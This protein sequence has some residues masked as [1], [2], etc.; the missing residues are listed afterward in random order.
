MGEVRDLNQRW[1][2]LLKRGN[3]AAAK[4]LYSMY[5]KA[6]YNTLIRITG[7]QE[8]AK[9]LLQDSFVKA[10]SSIDQLKDDLAFGGWLKRIV[11]NKGIEFTRKHNN[12]YLEVSDMLAEPEEVDVSPSISMDVINMKIAGLPDGCREIFTLYLVEGYTHKEISGFL[13]I[14]ESTSKSQYHRAR[15]LL[16]ESLEQIHD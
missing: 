8:D 4:Q 9:D 11:V 10:F 6:M 3:P 13:G 15:K 1:V 14:T 5:S 12:E 16:K 2:T 7:S